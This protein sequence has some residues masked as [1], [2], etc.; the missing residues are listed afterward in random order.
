MVKKDLHTKTTP[1]R[2]TPGRIILIYLIGY[3]FWIIATDVLLNLFV[4]DSVLITGISIIKGWFSVLLSGL[5][6]YGLFRRSYNSIVVLKSEIE[7]KAV[8]L[9]ESEE[10]FRTIIE[11]MQEYV[12]LTDFS[13]V[14]TFASPI[15]SSMFLYEPHEMIGHH[16]TEFLA[17]EAIPAAIDAFTKDVKSTTKTGSISLR[18][19]R[20]DGTY[21][22][23]EVDPNLYTKDGKTIG[24]IG[25]IRNVTERKKMELALI[26]ERDRAEEMTRLKSSFLANMSHEL[27][28]PMIGILGFSEILVKDLEG[29][30]LAHY[31]SNIYTSGSRL[32][33][34]LN[35]I[36]D[37]SRIEAGRLEVK[38]SAFNLV[39]I[40]RDATTTFTASALKKNL[41]LKVESDKEEIL[42]ESDEQM[43]RQIFH[44]LINNAI[45]YTN[46]GGV[47]VYIREYCSVSP[48]FVE[49][50]IA[51]TG[52]GIEKE[53]Q[54]FI[55]DEFRQ[56]SEGKGRNFEGTGLGLTITR[57]FIEKLNGSISIQSTPGEG[58]TFTIQLP[59]PVQVVQ[60]ALPAMP[61]TP[62][63]ARPAQTRVT[64]ANLL[65][66][67]DDPT[68]ISYTQLLLEK[69]YQLD[70]A[71]NS[72]A[73][74]NMVDQKQYDAILM[75]INLGTRSLDGVE[76]TK[77]IREKEHYKQTPIIAV[78]AFAMV[79]DREEFLAAGCSHYI[80]K[81]FKRVELTGILQEALQAPQS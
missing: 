79:G 28:T 32:M 41:Y 47:T 64:K 51:D 10:Q 48:G 22:I 65:Y 57:R 11:Q 21:F 46:T 62:A 40:L 54:E 77:L 68:A 53:H 23:G 50:S 2:L 16:F 30:P 15:A 18:M 6:L 52:I 56:V 58:A 67:E 75:D 70:I 17:E 19:K 24:T 9:R 1:S 78:T 55:W 25:V 5:L 39:R 81:P 74:L 42:I 20:K 66:V 35:M 80:C 69:D 26:K 76:T 4:T 71:V 44:N 37:M 13:G 34:T 72:S 45:K 49:I 14:I 36:L 38:S 12:F 8:Q 33:D 73:A 60:P 27:R 29:S 43:L 63:P 7:N 3:S 59:L 61:E 31:A